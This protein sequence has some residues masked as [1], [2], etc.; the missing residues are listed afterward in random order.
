MQN[1]SNVQGVILTQ[2]HLSFSDNFVQF[3]KKFFSIPKNE[4]FHI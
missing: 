4:I 1:L 2:K 3:S